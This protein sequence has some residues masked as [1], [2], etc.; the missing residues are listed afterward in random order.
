MCY[1]DVGNF[2]ATV[3]KYTRALHVSATTCMVHSRVNNVSYPPTHKISSEFDVQKRMFTCM[4]RNT[5]NRCIRHT[6][7]SFKNRFIF[8]FSIEYT[9][10]YTVYC[11]IFYTITSYSVCCTVKNVSCKIIFAHMVLILSVPI[12][13][14][15][16]RMIRNHSTHYFV[17]KIQTIFRNVLFQLKLHV[18]TR[19]TI[20]ALNCSVLQKEY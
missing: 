2:H 14:C 8:Q 3:F 13:K 1:Y 18:F 6:C 11:D 19:P 16:H 15:D 12:T 9:I 4:D 7:T 5:A 17:T 10:F 20:K